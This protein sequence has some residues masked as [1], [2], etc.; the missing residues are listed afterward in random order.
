MKTIV[1]ILY[2]GLGG[3]G[4]DFFSLVSGDTAGEYHHTAI[5]CG[6]E[7]MRQGYGEECNRLG[8]P[9][10]YVK[11]KQGA[12]LGFYVRLGKEIKRAS[13]DVLLVYGLSFLPSAVLYKKLRRR[14]PLLVRDTQAHHLKAKA[15]WY[16]LKMAFRFADRIVVLSGESANYLTE[17]FKGRAVAK[18]IVIPNGIDTDKYKPLT[19]GHAQ[20]RTL[21]MQSRLQVIKD[22]PVLL[23]AFAEVHRQHSGLKLEIAGDG[24]TMQNLQSITSGLSLSN[25][26]RFHGMLPENELIGFMHSLDLYIHATFGEM[27][28]TSI[29]QAMACGLPVIASDVWGVNNMITDGQDGLLY[30]SGNAADLAGR[31]NLLLSDDALRVRLANAARETAVNRFSKQVLFNRYKELFGQ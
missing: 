15:D 14:V 20:V 6:V 10:T 5:F 26:V 24:P 29:M 16:W 8:V 27:M 4:S 3:H 1:H 17:K 18:I 30:Q 19:T 12:D 2:S 7:P 22:H 11:K 9:F 28:S 31:I 23:Q 13:P 25:V 21:G